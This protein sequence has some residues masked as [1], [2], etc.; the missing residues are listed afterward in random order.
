MTAPR[1]A[2]RPVAR[3]AAPPP[4]PGE[5][6]RWA[7]LMP[8]GEIAGRDGRRFRLT[9]PDAV[10]ADFA[11][12]G[13]PLPVEHAGASARQTGRAAPAAGWITELK[14]GDAMLWARIDRTE[15]GRAM[16]AA[17]EH[18]FLS[19]EFH[20]DRRTGEVLAPPSAGL[21]HHP[22]LRL[23]ALNRQ[24]PVAMTDAPDPDMPGGAA[25]PIAER[26]RTALGLGEGAGEADALAAVA[27]LRERPDP[28][29]FV[30]VAAMRE[31]MAER[32][33]GAAA[34]AEQ[35]VGR[36][37]EDAL[38]RGCISRAMVPRATALCRND[39]ANFDALGEGGGGTD[40][41]A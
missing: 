19:P 3:H 36:K 18:R 11:R 17:R 37:V 21:V 9:R 38:A 20:C 5:A 26:L 32:H 7:Q 28:A 1:A 2:A 15:R 35:D 10:I 31:L 12:R 27:R 41:G 23:A 25:A 29:R 24:E 34:R 6:G 39:P 13:H 4:A 33:A 40:R 14:V 22:N 30:P 16:V 8:L